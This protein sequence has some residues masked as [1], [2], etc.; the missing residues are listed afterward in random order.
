MSRAPACETHLRFEPLRRALVELLRVAFASGGGPLGEERLVDLL[1]ACRRCS[2]RRR[3]RCR[4]G[5]CGAPR[6]GRPRSTRP[7]CRGACGARCTTRS[8]RSPTASRAGA[9]RCGSAPR[10][11]R[12]RSCPA[13]TMFVGH[14]PRE[15]VLSGVRALDQRRSRLRRRRIFIDPGLFADRRLSSSSSSSSPDRPSSAMPDSSPDARRPSRRV[16]LSAASSPAPAPSVAAAADRR[17]LPALRP[18]TRASD[19]ATTTRDAS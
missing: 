18:R 9:R 5:T 16:T 17:Q 4:T 19:P 8:R 10:T 7:R 12:C 11:G 3:A 15:L 13:R 6:P 1:Q 14:P 2:A